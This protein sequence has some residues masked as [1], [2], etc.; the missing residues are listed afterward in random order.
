[1]WK[2]V[3]CQPQVY[4]LVCSN[5]PFQA[6]DLMYLSFSFMHV[7][8]NRLT[9]L[10]ILECRSIKTDSDKAVQ[11]ESFSFITRL[12]RNYLPIYLKTWYYSIWDSSSTKI[13]FYDDPGLTLTYFTPKSNVIPSAF[14]LFPLIW[15]VH[16]QAVWSEV[17]LG[18]FNCPPYGQAVLAR[19]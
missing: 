19:K 7:H 8:V 6:F 9:S 13:T 18:V 4:G 11:F 2:S 12:L 10:I 14:L 16:I 3:W 15:K 5:A 17:L 1:M